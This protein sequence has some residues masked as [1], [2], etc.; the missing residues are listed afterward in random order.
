LQAITSVLKVRQ[1]I[2]FHRQRASFADGFLH[3][4]TEQTV[5]NWH[6][7]WHRT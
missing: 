6:R 1:G 3:D 5:S 7:D 2:G 4:S